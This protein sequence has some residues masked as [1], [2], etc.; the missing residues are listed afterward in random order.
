M[1]I[2][3]EFYTKY[4]KWWK[5]KGKFVYI[6]KYQKFIIQQGIKYY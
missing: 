2:G 1:Y 6:L 5:K 4:K 3:H